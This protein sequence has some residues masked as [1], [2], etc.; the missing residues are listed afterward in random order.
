MQDKMPI[1]TQKRRR[2]RNENSILFGSIIMCIVTLCAITVSLVMVFRYRAAQVENI[3]VMQELSDAQALQE[4]SYTKEEVEV[5]LSEQT[6]QAE[7]DGENAILSGIK[8]MLEEGSSIVSVLRAFYPNDIVIA[9]SNQY[10]FF[11][12]QDNLKKHT[13]QKENFI[14]NE[15]AVMEYY[16]NGNLISHKGIDVSKYQGEIDW[17][18]VAEDDVEYAFVRLGIRGYTEGEILQDETFEENIEGALDND[19]AVGVYFFTQAIS[20]KEA[21][22]EAKFVLDAIEPYD[23]TYPIVLDVEKV[24]RENAR[25]N[26]LTKEERTKYCLEFCKIIE[27]AG[28]TPMI[29]GNLRTFMLMLDME[30]IEEYDKWFA[31]YDSEV[32]FPYDFKIWQ[33]TDEGEVDGIEEAVDIN[34][35]FGDF[36]DQ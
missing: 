19:I 36:T 28:Y 1:R 24:S 27:N 25:A 17:E 14:Q 4:Q 31:Y 15:N 7:Q 13:Y 3:A 5:L 9:D 11:P 32:Y 33:Y 12:I 18:K 20:E 21:R 30:Q 16:E 6:A 26:G 2:K 23:V 8:K 35:S 22:E 10:L 34:I 29:Y